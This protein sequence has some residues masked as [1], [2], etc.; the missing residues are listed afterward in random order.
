MHYALILLADP[1]SE[2]DRQRN[3]RRCSIW[4]GAP[5]CDFAAGRASAS[6]HFDQSTVNLLQR[7][8]GRRPATAWEIEPGDII[9]KL[10]PTPGGILVGEARDV[11]RRTMSLFAMRPMEGKLLFSDVRLHDPWWVALEM[12]I[13]EVAILH[14]YPRPDLPN[15]A[16]ATAVDCATGE[17]LWRDDGLRVLCGTQELALVQ[18]GGSHDWSS[19]AL[20]DARSGVVLEEI[21]ASPERTEAFQ[22]TCAAVTEWPDWINSDTL[23]EDHP[24]SG[25]IGPILDRLLPARR[26]PVEIG[27]YA[28]YT[29]LGV[30]VPSRRSAD[31][32]LANLVDTHLLILRD[33][34]PVHQEIV[35]EDA[36]GPSS[37]IFFIWNGVL[38]FIRNRR[39]LAGIT[40]N[41]D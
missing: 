39:R 30:H 38:I 15:A 21:G 26:R 25:E 2:P 28:G 4:F 37:D 35:T 34:R 36:P 17:V 29:V 33:G 3:A 41:N 18:R 13:G 7:I 1:G 31:A 11:D 19:L 27:R 14:A 40:L 5:R 9:W 24:E 22:Q 6:P 32:M 16:G 12:T 23:D 8:F 20:I 10:Q